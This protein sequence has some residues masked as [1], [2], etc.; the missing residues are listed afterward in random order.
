MTIAE[1]RDL[2][3]ALTAIS[4]VVGGLLGVFKYFQYKTRRD[5]L[6]SVGEAFHGVVKSLASDV[7]VER[8]AGAIRLRRFFDPETELGIAGTPYADDAVNVI[9]GVLRTQR[10]GTFQKL[11]ADGLAYAPSLRRADLQR[12]NLQNAYL[13]VR[14]TDKPDDVVVDLSYADFYRADLSSASLKGAR[15]QHAVFYQARLNA[16]VLSRADL[17]DANFFEADLAGATFTGAVLARADFTN[18]RNVPRE[19]SGQLDERGKYPDD[20]NPLKPAQHAPTT[21]RPHVFLSKPGMLDDRQRQLVDLVRRMLDEQEMTCQ[22]IERSEYPKF[23][24]IAEVRRLMSGCAGAVIFGL[25][26]LDV[27]DGTW[28]LNT[29]E[30][31]PVVNVKLPTPWN[32]IEA[33]MAAMR[34]LPVL[35]V[36]Q[37]GVT[38]G[39]L[40][41]GG[42]D[43]LIFRLDPGEAASARPGGEPFAS[44]CAAVRERARA[45]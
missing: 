7:E 27:R 41:L 38:G 42:S 32:Q 5:K 30:E 40:D 8:I 33:G 2:A 17:S 23:G 15:A 45:G 1:L 29:A 4:G 18:A 35:L 6:L 12:T 16:T 24:L 43:D 39:I 19:I 14:K 21:H 3:A 22:T 44:W 36:S 28:R 31:A 13:G 9:A 34:G 10:T 11:L 37:P 20:W 26:Q 25:S